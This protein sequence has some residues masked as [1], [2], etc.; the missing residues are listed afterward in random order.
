MAER[1]SLLDALDF[2]ITPETGTVWAK[3]YS[4]AIGTA[5][6]RELALW[7]LLK[8]AEDQCRAARASSPDWGRLDRG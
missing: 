3:D 7:V 2:V 8:T 1:E 6:D 4:R 5:T